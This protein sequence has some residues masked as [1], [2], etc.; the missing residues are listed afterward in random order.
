MTPSSWLPTLD[1][2]LY[3]S[4][5]ICAHNFFFSLIFLFLLLYLLPLATSSCD[6]DVWQSV[7]CWWVYFVY[8]ISNSFLILFFLLLVFYFLC[9]CAP[10]CLNLSLKVYCYL[11][12]KCVM[13]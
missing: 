6:R 4:M 1:E 13:L 11:R 5:Y 12:E 10:V 8:Q 2:I 7:P 9:V 3:T